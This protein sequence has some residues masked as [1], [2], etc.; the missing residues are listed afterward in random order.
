MLSLSTYF[1]QFNSKYFYLNYF[2]SSI[3]IFVIESWASRILNSIEELGDRLNNQKNAV[4][5]AVMSK[6]LGEVNKDK[7]SEKI[8]ELQN[9]L[10]DSEKREKSMESKLKIL[11]KTWIYFLA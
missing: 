4:K 2:Y 9:K 1:T 6:R 8:R 10:A 3:S 5:D 7:L 11:G